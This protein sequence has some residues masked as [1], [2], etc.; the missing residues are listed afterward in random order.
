MSLRSVCLSAFVFSWLIM[1]S[2]AAVPPLWAEDQPLPTITPRTVFGSKPP[3]GPSRK[4]L[5]LDN[6]K[7]IQGLIQEGPTGY[8]VSKPEGKLVIA[9]D[10]VRFKAEDLQDAYRQ[11]RNTLPD[12][13]ASAHVELARWCMTYG[14]MDE[15]HKEAREALRRE[16]GSRIARNMLERI[17]EKLFKTNEL[18][19]V[20]KSN[21]GYSML[22]DAKPLMTVEAL[23]GLPREAASDFVLK[24]QPLLV[25][26]CATGGCHGPGSGNGF[27]LQRVKIGQGSSKSSSERNLASVLAL[28]DREQPGKSPLLT[29][30]RGDTKSLSLKPPHG[31]LSSEQ[32]QILR[33]WIDSQANKSVEKVVA[34][35]ASGSA[36]RHENSR[37]NKPSPGR[38]TSDISVPQTAADTPN[39]AAPPSHEN[40]RGASEITR[41]R[42][43][44]K[45]DS[46][47]ELS[48][49][50]DG[51]DDE[52][53]FRQ[54]L[55]ERKPDAFDPEQFNGK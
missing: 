9:F 24:L 18:P 15:A 11:Q 6:G 43:A 21:G 20:K 38:K 17:D 23:G 27:E 7:V 13:S 25:N 33:A 3:S 28:V 4:L 14:L 5:L 36:V 16:P 8:V 44:Q 49:A 29:K 40:E 26:R 30:L 22:G 42:H 46:K 35:S 1:Y 2:S 19:Q 53:F 39:A 45:V 32:M 34:K 41:E 37:L 10:Q 48:D 50:D 52:N 55:R 12:H 51:A 31:G 54:L 47:A